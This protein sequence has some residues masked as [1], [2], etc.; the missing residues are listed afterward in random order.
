MAKVSFR[1]HQAAPIAPAPH[2][3][4]GKTPTKSQKLIYVAEKLG[5]DGLAEMQG[6]TVNIVDTVPLV[7]G[8]VRQTLTFFSQSQGKS[9]NF[10]N[11]QN[12]A[13]KAGEAMVI[14]ELTFVLIVATTADLTSDANA[15]VNYLPLSLATE[16][17]YPNAESFFGGGLINISIANSKVVKDYNAFEGVPA[18][19]PRTTGLVSFDTATA[20]NKFFGSS[21]IKLESP[22]VLPPNQVISV[23]IEISPTGTIPAFTFIQCI[24]GRFGSIFAAKAT[25]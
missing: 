11:F 23:T 1:R 19:N 20:T 4:L 21:T 6:S 16:T 18:F 24:A 2:P 5:L 7:T 17:Q 8:A 12:G 25:L 22:P 3:N 13:L 9:R 14:E 10:S 15:I